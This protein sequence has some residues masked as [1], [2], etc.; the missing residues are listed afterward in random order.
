MIEIIHDHRMSLRDS[1][2]R[3]FIIHKSRYEDITTRRNAASAG[4]VQCVGCRAL[5]VRVSAAILPNI[6][7]MIMATIAA[8]PPNFAD[9]ANFLEISVPIFLPIKDH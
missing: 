8:I 1:A 2:I 7:P 4:Y 9:T 5:E 6:T 3:H